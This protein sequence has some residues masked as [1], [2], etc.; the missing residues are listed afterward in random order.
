CADC[1]ARSTSLAVQSG[2]L[3]MTL[4]LEGLNTSPQREVVLCCHLPQQSTSTCSTDAGA[5][6]IM[7]KPLIAKSRTV[8]CTVSP[9]RLRCFLCANGGASVIV[10]WFCAPCFSCRRR[11][12]FNGIRDGSQSNC[13][14][15]QAVSFSRGFDVL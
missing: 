15:A 1:T 3:A 6:V 10:T 4:P 11:C 5:S 8:N 13:R 14:E 7:E 2:T 9:P 12:H